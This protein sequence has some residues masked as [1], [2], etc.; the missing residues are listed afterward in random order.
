MAKEEPDDDAPAIYRHPT[1]K[2]L[3][4]KGQQEAKKGDVRQFGNDEYESYG[5]AGTRK[6]G[7]PS[8]DD[9][10][11]GDLDVKAWNKARDEDLQEHKDSA[12]RG[13]KSYK[14]QLHTTD[15]PDPKD[16]K[17]WRRQFW[18]RKAKPTS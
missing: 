12:A 4:D 13:E 6:G 16:A 17:G 10:D 7:N 1:S 3:K 18:R 15:D 2:A 14:S 5:S 11:E 9:D 8:K